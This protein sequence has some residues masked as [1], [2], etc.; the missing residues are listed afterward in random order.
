M[1]TAALTEHSQ[2]SATVLTG[3]MPYPL[4][5]DLQSPE[6]RIEVS[7]FGFEMAASINNLRLRSEE[8]TFEVSVEDTQLLFSLQ[9]SHDENETLFYIES[10]SVRFALL[11]ERPQA[12]FVS[13]TLVALFAL[14][15]SRS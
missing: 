11:E 9:G 4:P 14:S 3:T 8:I 15:I 5:S 6:L 13:S 2:I 7:S 12:D 10:V 1:T